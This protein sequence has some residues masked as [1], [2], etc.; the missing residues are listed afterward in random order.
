MTV[1]SKSKSNQAIALVL[2]VGFVIGL[3]G[4]YHNSLCLSP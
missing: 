1:K 3:F 2:V 4:K